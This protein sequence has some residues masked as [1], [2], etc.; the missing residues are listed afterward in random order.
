MEIKKLIFGLIVSASTGT[1]FA[2]E[3]IWRKV[4][5][6]DKGAAV[7]DVSNYQ[8]TYAQVV[9][10]DKN[11]VNYLRSQG[12]SLAN[13]SEEI[14][15]QGLNERPVYTGSDFLGIRIESGDYRGTLATAYREGSGLK[16]IFMKMHDPANGNSDCHNGYATCGPAYPVEAGNWYFRNCK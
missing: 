1:S 9:I 12:S 14:I 11:I 5:D 3:G 8:A 15:L 4:L 2:Q 6:C 16:V 13:R 10:R 7:V